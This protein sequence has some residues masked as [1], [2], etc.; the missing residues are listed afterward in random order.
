MSSF[1]VTVWQKWRFQR[2]TPGGELEE[3]GHV[4][5]DGKQGD[6]DHERPG[7][8]DVPEM[9]LTVLPRAFV[10]HKITTIIISK[11]LL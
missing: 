5:D 10:D 8:V 11:S 2:G 7:G 3:L 1:S 6:R 4:V 9:D